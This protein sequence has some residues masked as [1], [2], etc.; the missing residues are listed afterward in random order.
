[1]ILVGRPETK[2]W[3]RNF[4]HEH[5]VD[6]LLQGRWVAATGRAVLGSEEPDEVLSLL[7]AYGREFPRA[8]RDS[9]AASLDERVRRAVFVVCQPR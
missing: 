8:T 2:T 3:W 7:D 6:L 4:R 5:D 9:N 1:V